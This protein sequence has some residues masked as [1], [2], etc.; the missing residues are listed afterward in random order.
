MNAGTM[1]LVIYFLVFFVIIYV[2]TI[3]PQQKQQKARQAMLESLR[4][5]DK[6]IT[7]GGIYGK[8]TKV[9]ADSAL[10]QIADKVEIEVAKSGIGSVENRKVKT[11][12]SKPKKA[13]PE[14]KAE[15]K[16]EATAGGEKEPESKE[17]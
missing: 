14:A 4:V 3:R 17:G 6:I 10:V 15:A 9:K 8:V 2:F 12:D 7:T 13:K 1:T 5:N 16:T 11:E